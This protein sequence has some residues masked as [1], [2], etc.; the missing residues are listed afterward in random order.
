MAWDPGVWRAR[1][2]RAV[3]VIG[4]AV[5]L[6]LGACGEPATTPAH[7]HL[8]VAGPVAV[9]PDQQRAVDDMLASAR[10]ATEVYRDVERARRDG[11]RQ[12][13][14]VLPGSSAHLVSQANIDDGV[15]DPTRPEMLL[16]DY[17]PDLVGIAF[18]VP[19]QA[20]GV[21]PAQFAPLAHWHEHDFHRS[22]LTARVAGHPRTVRVPDADCR[23]R[24]DVVIAPGF[25]M[26]HVWLYRDSPDGMFAELNSTVGTGPTI[27]AG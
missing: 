27:Y 8:P 11:F 26:L 7:H 17:G 19:A 15:L 10:A 22:C 21:A 18:M 2:A 24:G 13:T 5:A 1:L 25:W 14:G 20:P 12:I 4:C 6:A 23:A 3:I 16:Y 9:S